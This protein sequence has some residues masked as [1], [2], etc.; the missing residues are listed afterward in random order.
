MKCLATLLTALL[1]LAGSA[2]PASAAS[3]T[4][5]KAA[6]AKGASFLR[7]VAGKS[8]G[9]EKTLVALALLKSGAAPDSPEIREALDEVLKKF[10]EGKY[11][12]GGHHIY[13]AGV[14]ATLLADLD[15]VRYKPQIQLLADYI[16]GQ[17]KNTGGW[18]YPSGHPADSPGDTSV[19]QYALLGLWAAERAGV[20][21]NPLVW[22]RTLEWHAQYQ[23]KDGGF[24]YIPGFQIGDGQGNSTL[25]MSVN[26]VGSMHIAMSFIDPTFLPLKETRPKTDPEA[27]K[28]DPPKFGILEQV[29]IDA[30]TVQEAKANIPA[31]AVS[32]VRRAFQF[33]SN[34]FQ[35]ENKE[36]GNKV[37]YYYSLERMAAFA[38]VREIAGRDWFNECAD[39]LIAQQKPDGSWSM[40][41]YYG[42]NVDTS[43][44]VLFL[45]RSTGKL[46]KR[47]EPEPGFGD[48][49]LAGG[50]GLPDDLASVEFDGQRVKAK[51]K[52]SGSFEELLASLQ[53]SGEISLEDVQT[54]FVEKIQLG[55]RSQLIGKLDQLIGLLKHPDAEIRRTAVWAI[56]RSNDFSAAMHLIEAL[57]DTDLGVIV[58]AQKALCWLSRKPTGFG[59]A[60]DPRDTLPENATDQQKKDAISSW[61]K[62]VVVTWGN[63]YLASRPFA[64][65]GDDFEAN[66]R[67]KLERIRLGGDSRN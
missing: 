38:D 37:Y 26:A 40:S 5:V 13:E 48:G 14:E 64:D 54:Q 16:V 28:K 51:E 63:W 33:V 65:R 8:H 1:I 60:V 9:G 58:E 66:F 50:R 18:D 20:K 23:S 6:I 10:G 7:V 32:A 57:S 56:G 30:P 15:A 17:Q 21:V 3:P 24:A 39:F 19:I 53:T 36:T 2:S 41:Q 62:D 25:N 4:D 27:E 47:I 52:P 35:A 46:L 31:S 12:A 55:D 67:L 29:Q 22:Q 34:R 49:T 59:F 42:A 61:H 44:A 11:Q 43:F 45:T